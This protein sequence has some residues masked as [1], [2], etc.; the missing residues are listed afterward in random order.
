M[1]NMQEEWDNF[2]EKCYPTGIGEQQR[3][4]LHQAFFAGA[5]CSLTLTYGE[6]GLTSDQAFAKASAV[7]DEVKSTINKMV[8]Q[9]RKRN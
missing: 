4:Q 1:K 6:K 5:W 8:E 7:I 3:R 2:L 9:H